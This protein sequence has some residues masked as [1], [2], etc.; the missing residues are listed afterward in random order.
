LVAE[1]HPPPQALANDPTGPN[2]NW[3]QLPSTAIALAKLGTAERA[4]TAKRL[5]INSN[6]FILFPPDA[7]F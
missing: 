1:T 3:C 5:K 2:E 4:K 6:F 7:D